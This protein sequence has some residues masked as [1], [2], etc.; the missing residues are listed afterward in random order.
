MN[1]TVLIIVAIVATVIVILP[2]I[3]MLA[4]NRGNVADSRGR[5]IFHR[6]H[7]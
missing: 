2:V 3:L 4:F 6:W 5:R 1:G 7:T